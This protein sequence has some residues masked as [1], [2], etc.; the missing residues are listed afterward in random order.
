VSEL[1]SN[2]YPDET[3][4]SQVLDAIGPMVGDGAIGLKSGDPQ[5]LG[6]L[7]ERP[8]DCPRN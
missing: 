5:A 3:W 8:L 2:A 1:I 4:T 7:I 6:S